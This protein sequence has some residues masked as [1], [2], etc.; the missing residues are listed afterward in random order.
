VYNEK[1]TLEPD[2]YLLLAWNFKDEILPKFNS[3]REKGGKIL[4]PIPEPEFI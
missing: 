4:I 3:F 2:V 1:D